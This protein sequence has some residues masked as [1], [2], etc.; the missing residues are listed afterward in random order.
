MDVIGAGCRSRLPELL[1]SLRAS[2]VAMITDRNVAPRWAPEVVGQ[3]QSLGFACPVLELAPGEESK[4]PAGLAQALDFLEQQRLDRASVVLAL[5]GGTVGDLAGFA[6]S[7][8]LRG[9]RVVQIP[10]TLLAMIDSAVGGKTAINSAHSKN[11]IGTFWQPSLV[12]SDLDF[13]S[14]LTEEEYLAAYGE[15]VKYA[16]AMDQ[17]LAHQLDQEVNRLR[18]RD[19]GL[20]TLLIARCVGLK[21]G[22]VGADEQDRG[23][24]AIL[25][26]GHTIG[27]AIEAA[28]G[29]SAVHG[30]AVAMGMRGAVRLAW[31]SGL[32]EEGLIQAQ[33]RLLE[34]YSL[35]GPLPRVDPGQVLAGL[36]RDKKSSAG[37][38]GWVLPV[39]LGH[40]LVG[41]EV[42]ERHLAPVLEEI[43]A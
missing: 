27:H 20:L 25:N 19:G 30:R 29:Y 33:D 5:G 21:A 12:L 40:A 1:Q 13:L 42:E 39:R 38:I 4:S 18:A 3:V 23:A 17:E 15:V 6:S 11:S 35:P 8:W 7:I 9:V 41:Q 2:G 26:Y 36:S 32:C 16:V 14:S 24:R 43:L 22:V 34:A 37:R 28:S 31:R 10:T